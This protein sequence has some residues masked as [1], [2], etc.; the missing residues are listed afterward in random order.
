MTIT[1]KVA[2]IKGL[3]EGLALDENNAQ[4]KVLKAIVDALDDIA[5]TVSDNDERLEY[6]EGYVDELDDDLAVLEDEVYGDEDDLDDYDECGDCEG[7][8]GCDGFDETVCVECPNCGE[9]VYL[10]EDMDFDNIKCPSCGEE[11]SCEIS[12]EDK[13]N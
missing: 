10:D 4:T 9:K 6:V 3:M 1:E 12:D 2:Y 11:F 5:L 8:D 13:D 7:C